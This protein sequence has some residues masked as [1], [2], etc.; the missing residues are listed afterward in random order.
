RSSSLV[1]ACPRA[2]GAAGRPTMLRGTGRQRQVPAVVADLPQA[3]AV[4]RGHVTGSRTIPR[5]QDRG[6]VAGPAPAEADVDQ[7][8]DD[9]ADHLVTERRRLDP[10][11]EEATVRRHLLL[12]AG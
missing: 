7:R 11:V 2:G 6:H 5:P 4:R 9:R 10:E 12:E 8:A 3:Q 1:T